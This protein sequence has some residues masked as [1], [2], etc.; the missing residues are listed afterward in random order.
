MPRNVYDGIAPYYDLLFDD[1]GKAVEDE[2]R[3]LDLLLRPRGVRSVLDVTC[4]TGLQCIGLAKSGY[5]VTGMDC[6]RGMLR[7]A[8]LNARTV[9]ARVTWVEGDLREADRRVS[10]PFDCAI[11]CGNSLA[12]VATEED[13]SRS[14]AAMHSLL[15]PGGLCLID[16]WDYDAMLRDKPS[17]AY[18]RAREVAGRRVVLFDEREYRPNE[19]RVTFKLLVETP[20][21][22]LSREFAMD[23][24]PWAR[25]QVEGT[26]RNVGFG[27]IECFSRGGSIEMVA[28]RQ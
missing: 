23:L 27:D 13:L 4:G 20:E 25:E 2:G 1:W 21:R 7:R 15:R 9:G 8:R 28:R 5:S 18:G 17:N 6:S 12:H 3:R 16:V 11:S 22:W 10:G 24:R 14:V 26:L 19:V